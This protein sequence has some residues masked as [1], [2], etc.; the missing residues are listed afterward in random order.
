[1]T[2]NDET[3]RYQVAAQK[4]L[5]LQDEVTLEAWVQADKMAQS[6]GRILDKSVSGTNDG[7]LFDTYPGNSLRFI[8]ANGALTFDA[9]LPADNW[10]HVVAVYSAPR[11]IQKLF[12]NGQ[13]VAS[14]DDGNFPQLALTKLPLAVGADPN[15]GNH[16][17]GR[18]QRA[19]IYNRALRADEI[20]ARAT[21]PQPLSGVLGEW[22][23]TPTAGISIAPLAGI[24]ALGN[25]R[26]NVV[27]TE[28]SNPPTA[29][30]S[31]WYRR[32]AQKW[33]EALP[34]GNGR[35][36]A[37][38][39][40]GVV[41]ETLQLNTD[42]FWTGS[43]Y[44]SNHPEGL[45]ALGE[46]RKLI[47]EGKQ[48]EADKAAN[49]MMSRPLGQMSYQTVGDL[50][51][52]FP[53]HNKVA[54]YRRALD[55]DTAI[56]TTTFEADGVGFTR[57]MFSSAPDGVLVARLS[58]DKPG[59]VSFSVA[60]DS[61]QNVTRRIENGNTLVVEGTPNDYRG[62]KSVLKF[63]CRVR[64]MAQGGTLKADGDTLVLQ[65]AD[66]AL[67]L[68]D[69]DTNY[70]NYHDTSAD[71]NAST[72][73]SIARASRKSFTNLRS[74]HIDDYQGLFRRVALDLGTTQAAT[75]PTDERV[76][77]FANANDP[78]L[79]ALYFQY[80]RY[81]L[82]A[83]SR[84]GTQ[85]ANLQGIWNNST[86]PPW[87]SKYTININ[88]EMNYWPSETTN[89]SELNQPLIQMLSEMAQTGQRTAQQLYGARGWVAHH[90]TD[91]WRATGPIDGPG[92]GLWPTGGAW[93][94]T[95]LWEHYRFTGDKKF[96]ARVYP[97]LKGASLF[98]VDTLVKHPQKGWL[99]T[100]PSTSPEHGGLVAGPTMDMG[101]VRDLFSATAAAA[102]VLAVDSDLRREILQKRAQLAPFQIGKHGQLQEWLEDK[103]D[104]KED[105]RHVSHLYAVFPSNQIT[106]QTPELFAAAKQSLLF[107]GDGGTGWSKA[108][109]INLWARFLDGDHAYKMLSE[110]IS[111]NTYPNLFDAHPPFQIDGNFGGTS[112]IAEMLLQSQNG[113]I[114]L[115]PAL[116]STWIN[117]NVRGLKARGGF[118]V[119]IAW[120]AGKLS[121][122]TIRSTFGTVTRVRAGNQTVNL[123]LKKGQSMRLD[124][125]LKSRRQ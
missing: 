22:E 29:P 60:L 121:Q 106:P 118:E 8:T 21:N 25:G 19:A 3:P 14:K 10:T 42:T 84:A 71:P 46:V 104:P 87:D 98:F 82:I 48:S 115:L 26:E 96:L 93:L 117:G 49:A 85:P 91:L 24:L 76:K 34:L 30:L 32:P 16:F 38:V 54:H 20:A 79:A 37:M 78:Q 97:I 119:D 123:K 64:V 33:E 17:Q 51:L 116:P 102:Q 52:N 100:V 11:K 80:G 120:Q 95:H 74:A 58:A 111:G 103:D 65:G 55:L 94:C 122:A 81:L 6:G 23:F 36:G 90:N 99:V 92:W 105:H 12:L 86:N 77:N 56:A 13:Q 31:L 69:I 39:F 125:A 7:Y 59:Q 83:S 88:T 72:T 108:W 9:Q 50:K 62:I 40:G 28:E 68:L 15:G 101:I 67:L 47:F 45:Q 112:G 89:L 63:G 110:A 75:L 57:E 41:Q 2:L 43:P 1:M 61:P 109:K 113:E 44:D 66:S 124:D 27:F 70:K 53:E 107:R 4:S 5:D 35:L 114:V 73:L 18:I